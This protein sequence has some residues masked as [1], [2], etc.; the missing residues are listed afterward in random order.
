MPL[1][2]SRSNLHDNGR[3]CLLRSRGHHHR[4]GPGIPMLVGGGV[5]DARM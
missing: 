1:D 4:F 2:G 5:G 3:T